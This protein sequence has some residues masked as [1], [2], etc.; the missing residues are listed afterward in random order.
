MTMSGTD[1]E[2]TEGLLPSRT[3]TLRAS[4]TS[5]DAMQRAIDTLAVNGFDH[6]DLGL[7]EGDSRNE[8]IPRDSDTKPAY[9][10]AD[11]RQARTLHA[12]GAA[13][14]AGLAAAGITVATGGLAAVAIGAAV[15]AGAAAGGIT[16]AISTAANESEQLERDARAA[17]GQLVLSVQVPTAEKRSRAEEILHAAG[18]RDMKLV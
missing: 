3:L 15:V 2:G 11:A 8:A 1:T 7:I 4:F 6:A 13:T 9:G 10:E 18:A 16:H 14:A 12:S 17:D 5:A